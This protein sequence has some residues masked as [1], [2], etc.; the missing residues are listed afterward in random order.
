MSTNARTWF[1]EEPEHNAY[2]IV[3]R[4]NGTF[5]QARMGQILVTACSQAEPPFKCRGQWRDE[6]FE[7]EWQPREWLALRG[8]T[9]MAELIPQMSRILGF[10]P[11]FRYMDAED[12]RVYEWHRDAA[13]GQTRWHAIQGM[14]AFKHP[15][16]LAAS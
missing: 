14:P 4:L 16:R 3:E 2:A 10:K 6:P 11:A 8:P 5:W 13:N 9:E 15:E 7:L 12:W 1:F